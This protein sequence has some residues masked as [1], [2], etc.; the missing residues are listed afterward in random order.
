MINFSPVYQ[1]RG[2]IL[3]KGKE[4]LVLLGIKLSVIMLILCVICFG[5][6]N[7]TPSDKV[8]NILDCNQIPLIEVILASMRIPYDYEINLTLPLRFVWDLCR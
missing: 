5:Y 3:F 7:C 4:L 6:H 1:T 8:L 2:A